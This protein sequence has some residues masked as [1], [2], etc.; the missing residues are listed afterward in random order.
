MSR[1]GRWLGV[2][3]NEESAFGVRIRWRFWVFLGLVLAVLL[4]VGMIEYSETPEFC[5]SCHIM[6]PYYASWEHSPHGEVACVECHYPPGSPRTIL[7][8][9]IQAVNQVVQYVTDTYTSRPYAHVTDASCLRSNC[10][11]TSLLA[12]R[13]LMTESGIHFDHG[14]HLSR[15][16]IGRELRCV[17]C[18]S[19]ITVD[20]HIETNYDTCFLCH[21]K[22][23]N[24]GRKLDALGG[25]LGCHDLPAESFEVGNMT[26]NH[27]D[28]V[29]KRG[30]PCSNCH[31]DVVSGAG[32]APAER[33]LGCHNRQEDLGRYGEIS[34]LHET[35]V[36]QENVDCM[37]CHE[38]IR[39]GGRSRTT[40]R[41]AKLGSEPG[42]GRPAPPDDGLHQATLTF[43]CS[44]CHQQKHG[45]QLLMYSGQV[46]PLGLPEMPS[47]MYV[48]EVD[49]IGCHYQNG[50]GPAEEF[51]GI[52]YTASDK[53]CIKCHGEEFRGIWEETEREFKATLA[54][55][56]TK[57]TKVTE[58]LD[59]AELE[60]AERDKLRASLGQARR[61]HDFVRYSRGEH[62]PYLGSLVLRKEDGL[63]NVMGEE[64][65]VDLANL[66]SLPLISG[67][68]CAT[69]C[70]AKVGVKVPPEEVMAEAFGSMMPHAMHADMVSCVRCHEIGSHKEVPLRE[71]VFEVCSECH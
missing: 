54:Y 11:A 68:F 15:E 28:F 7:W 8:K 2:Q 43:D 33:C 25:C 47:P 52:T 48:A 56:D 57:I 58:S 37:H 45:G 14:P 19:Q 4:G 31:L 16:T 6:D 10:H 62:N 36:A 60:E 22:G 46:E 18:H 21:F 61:W 17:S 30:I 66:S 1:L 44:F 53:A 50:H 3:R 12:E 27:E 13:P 63:L 51:Q 26:Y 9:K 35:H 64:L 42:G 69:M 29:T 55:L 40:R 23:R 59:D 5:H 49:C 41:I 65:D 24:G 20:Q 38:E 34:F 67:G 71:D 70:H 32:D 39:H